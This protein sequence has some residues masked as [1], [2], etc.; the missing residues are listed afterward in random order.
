MSSTGVFQDSSRSKL[1][2]VDLSQN[3][4]ED[5]RD[6]N[7]ILES[8]SELI[9]GRMN[10]AGHKRFSIWSNCAV[11]SNKVLSCELAFSSNVIPK[12]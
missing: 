10:C 11:F 1:N 4:M 7:F 3:V 12:T 8:L 5:K 9:S 6:N 2:C